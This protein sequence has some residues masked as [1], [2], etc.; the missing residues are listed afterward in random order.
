MGMS[1]SLCGCLKCAITELPWQQLRGARY[2]YYALL[3]P[4]GR[5]VKETYNLTVSL[6]RASN[7]LVSIWVGCD[8]WQK[9]CLNPDGLLDERL[10][11]CY[12]SAQ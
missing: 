3:M 7:S 10:S 6:E 9:L 2:F 5:P 12:E 1:V 4:E 8:Q 11:P